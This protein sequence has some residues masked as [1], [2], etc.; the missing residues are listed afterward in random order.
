MARATRANRGGDEL[1]AR[2]A[3][4]E[5]LRAGHHVM[6]AIALGA[7]CQRGDVAAAAG[8]G[9]RER[10]NRAVDETRPHEALVLLRCAE[11]DDRRQRDAV[12]AQAN[13][14]ADRAAGADQLVACDQHVADVAA[15]PADR[16]GIA[17]AR[18]PRR[19]GLLVELDRELFVLF[20]LGSMRSDVD[21]REPPRRR[22]NRRMLLGLEQISHRRPSIQ[23]AAHVGRGLHVVRTRMALPARLLR[24]QHLS[25]F[26]H[27]GAV[28]LFHD[29]YGYLME[30][31][32]DIADLIESFES[33]AD[34][35]TVLE[36]FAN[37][38]E[39]ADPAQFI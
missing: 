37:R 31:S 20:P 25:W 14:R 36:R 10:R 24:S 4:D 1:R 11:P 15:L 28:Y 33:E 35:A 6:I 16:L 39:G 26:A 12:R 23:L 9:D 3:R 34:T 7:G 30:M 22:A 8:L 29:L 32:P 2:S 21:L 18:D 13:D 19:G 38:F 17:D 27:M 5:G